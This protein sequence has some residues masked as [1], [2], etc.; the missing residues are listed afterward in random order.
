MKQCY[1]CGGSRVTKRTGGFSFEPPKN[2]SLKENDVWVVPSAEWFECED[3]G[4]QYIPY[5]LS[6]TLEDM[7][8]VRRRHLAT[9]PTDKEN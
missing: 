8:D 2:L 1:T 9:L 5:A 7:A 3:C 6:R 4:A